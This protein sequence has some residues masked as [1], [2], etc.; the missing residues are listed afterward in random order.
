MRTHPKRTS[1]VFGRTMPTLET[2]EDRTVPA[3]TV[4]F[5]AG[6]LSIV[7]DNTSNV[8]T[9]NDAGTG[10]IGS[11]SVTAD[12]V[13]TSNTA[14][15]TSLSITVN[16]LGGND[17]VRYNLSDDLQ[18]G[19]SRTLNAN[20]GDKNDFFQ[21]TSLQ[22]GVGNT[23][24]LISGSSLTFNINGQKG[25][26]RIFFDFTKDMDV[27]TT[28]A[29]IINANGGLD[30]DTIALN[31]QGATNGTLNFNLN[32]NQDRDRVAAYVALNGS[33][34]GAVTGQVRGQA[35]DDF[36]AWVASISN[37]FT[38]TATGTLDGGP[39]LDAAI[40]SVFVTTS[41]V[42]NLFKLPF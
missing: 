20:L 4:S 7:G 13:T 15:I 39:G 34:T 16:T 19:Q 32:G 24:D 18:T 41:G 23:A 2:L 35:G 1:R 31:Y 11:V 40:A 25:R 21:A 42:E 3:S 22:D 10:G 36:L 30:R 9:I 33:S 6:T 27:E 29:L 28:A 26:D 38:G 14:L 8:V 5:G 12:G 17:V 37:S